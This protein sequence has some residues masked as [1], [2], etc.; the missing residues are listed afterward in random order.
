VP[1]VAPMLATTAARAP[2]GEGWAY[3]LKWDG[4]RAVVRAAAGAVTVTSRNGRDV[5]ASYPELA[6]LAA[7]LPDRTTLDAEIVA[8]DAA[9][10]PNFGVLQS[11]MHVAHP[12]DALL[13]AIPV[14]LLAFDLLELAGIPLLA[15]PYQIRREALADLDLAGPHWQVPPALPGPG[16]AVLAASAEQGLEGV[17]AKRQD[18]PYLPG[19]RSDAWVKVKNVRRQEVVVGGWEPG[20]GGRAGRLGALLVGVY[21]GPSLRYAGQVGTGFSD[22]VLADLH[23]RLAPL[24]RPT[25]PFAEPV[26]RPQTRDAR[27]VEPRL[28]CE[29]AF[30]AWTKEGRLRHPAYKGLRTDKDPTEVV[31]E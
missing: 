4:V 11:R 28:V 17:V 23:A 24:A 20:T 15:Q 26:P 13:A 14:V 19:V 2:E 7:V 5:T 31:R 3:E 6:G 9:G 10:V 1:P 25:P 22:R 27:W 30:S 21:D 18:S 8:L 12:P 29:V 16:A